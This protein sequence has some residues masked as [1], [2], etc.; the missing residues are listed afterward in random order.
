MLLINAEYKAVNAVDIVI[1][2]FTN[3]WCK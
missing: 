3:Y 2:K 1:S